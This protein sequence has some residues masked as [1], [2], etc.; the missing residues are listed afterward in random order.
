MS[1]P[2][3]STTSLGVGNV[4]MRSRDSRRSQSARSARSEQ[5]PHAFEWDH[6]S[7]CRSSAHINPIKLKVMA[8]KLRHR[9]QGYDFRRRAVIA[10][11]ELNAPLVARSPMRAQQTQASVEVVEGPNNMLGLQ[12]IFL[13]PFCVL[14]LAAPLGIVSQ[15]SDWGD[16]ATF[17][18]N[19]L[20][21]V[22]LAKILGDATEELAA[23]LH[24]D[25]VSGLLNATFGNA[26]EM[27]VSIQSIRAGLLSVV[28]MSLL[29]SVLSN[30]LL[31]LGTAF[32]L[33]GLTKSK[34]QKGPF[35]TF[36]V[37]SEEFAR[38]GA[39]R[40]EKEQKFPLKGALISMSLL[41]FSC[42]SFAL[43]T[44]F[45]AYPTDD[46]KAV[47]KVSRIGACIVGSSYIAYLV[48]Q[49][50]THHET[51]G[52]E[53]NA[54]S[55]E[56]GTEDGADEDD[57]SADD[58]ADDAPSL[59]SSCALL[60]M[61]ATTLVVAVNSAFLIDTLESVVKS[62]GIPQT[63][64]GVIL[65]PIAGNACEHASAIRFAMQDRPGLAIGISVGSSTQIALLV[66]PFSVI[67]AWIVGQPLDLDFGCLNVAVVTLSILVV[68]TLLLDGRSNWFK[69]YIM[70]SMYAFI[71]VLYWYTPDAGL[72]QVPS[73]RP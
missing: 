71:A 60:L 4:S 14:L 63:F 42:M 53:E 26:V 46:G 69:G 68:L 72:N 49:L 41:L 17:W 6:G 44:I 37:G 13:H 55:A 67:M 1:L 50:Y 39:T 57:E 64:I 40:M 12:T 30:I 3:L 66:V 21:L 56:N 22:P 34:K 32:L 52:K 9:V 31:V 36:N 38:E 20:A 23:N 7:K 16:S 24:N 29:G 8:M 43:P 18:L 62:N 5:S 59:T 15:Y 70:C 11:G 51:L 47:L 54:L 27:I 35:H 10:N 28:K 25:T 19:F 33:G 73:T 61:A 58:E 2:L 65:L 45:N 48:F